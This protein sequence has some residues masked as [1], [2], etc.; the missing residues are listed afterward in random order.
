M[1]LKGFSHHAICI[2]LFLSSVLVDF[3]AQ[4]LDS[5]SQNKS[6]IIT[7]QDAITFRVAVS[8]KFNAFKLRSKEDD[9]SAVIRPNQQ[10]NSTFSL[11]FRFIEIDIGYTPTFIKFNNDDDKNGKTNFFNLATR[12][13]IKKWIQNLEFTKTKGFFIESKDFGFAKENNIIFPDLKVLKI[14]GSSAYSFNPNFSF[15][16]IFGQTEWQRKSSGSFVP[17]ISYYYTQFKDDSNGIDEYIDLVAG[18]SYFYNWTLTESLMVSG[19]IYG[20]IGYSNVHS[21]GFKDG[22]PNSTLDGINYRTEITL[23]I[24]YNTK[25]IFTGVMASFNSFYHNI[26]TNFRIDDHQQ[27]L[28]FHIGYR[29][30]APKKMVQIMDIVESKLGI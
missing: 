13:Y 6:T 15:R 28:E 11:Q 4:A 23:A 21:S 5:I 12:F 14:G 27:F 2:I 7:Y 18:P 8:D 29:F 19:G 24:G 9:L 22:T 10:I 16:S 17:T 20:G 1:I 3:H 25:K 30:D 26:E